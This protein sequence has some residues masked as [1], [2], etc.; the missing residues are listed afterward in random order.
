L[1]VITLEGTRNLQDGS[2]LVAV[3]ALADFALQTDAIL[4][5][6]NRYAFLLLYAT[7]HAAVTYLLLQSWSCWQVPLLL[8]VSH[9]VIDCI[10]LTRSDDGALAFILTSW[11]TWL[12]S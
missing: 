7:L 6:K 10:K 9:A 4:K 8:L 3:H 1:L 11:P 2:V 5:R 12:P